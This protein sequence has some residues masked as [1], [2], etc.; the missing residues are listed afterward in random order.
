MNHILL[1]TNIL[2]DR[3]F[4]QAPDNAAGIQVLRGCQLRKWNGY[5]TPWSV[6]TM[7]YLMDAARDSVDRRI[8]TKAQIM[9]EV[10]GLLTFITLVEGNNGAFTAGFSLGW[11]DWEDAV[12]YSIAESHP[13]IEAIVT[14]DK[15][16]VTRTKKLPGVK[17]IPPAELTQA[18][19]QK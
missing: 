11:A 9:T 18:A 17:A 8:W 12:L 13:Q 6:M 15:G 14:N 1:D 2:L 7:M 5:A 10:A 4:R 19:A 3:S 16:F